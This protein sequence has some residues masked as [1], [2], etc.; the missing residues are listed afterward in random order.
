[1][2]SGF[3]YVSEWDGG[4]VSIHKQSSAFVCVQGGLQGKGESEN[5]YHMVKLRNHEMPFQ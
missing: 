4:L 1:M 3:K 5:W 2:Q